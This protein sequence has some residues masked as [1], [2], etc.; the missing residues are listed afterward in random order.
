MIAVENPV[1]VHEIEYRSSGSSSPRD[2]T[3]QILTVRYTAIRDVA[4]MFL[5]T[6]TC[7]DGRS[8]QGTGCCANWQPTKSLP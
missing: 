8:M 3:L 4:P 5:A 6:L 2:L 7:K 1:L